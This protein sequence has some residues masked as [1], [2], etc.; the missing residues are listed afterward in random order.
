MLVISEHARIEGEV[1]AE[2]VVVDGYIAG[3]VYCAGTA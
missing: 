1:S 2:H 3:P